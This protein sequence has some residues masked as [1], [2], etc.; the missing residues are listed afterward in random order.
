MGTAAGQ[1]GV[2]LRT[3]AL[4][5]TLVPDPGFARRHLALIDRAE[6]KSRSARVFLP[7]AVP[8][9]VCEAEGV[10]PD[11]ATLLGAVGLL[12]WAGADLLDDLAD[13]PETVQGDPARAT[14]VAVN[15]LTTLP[16]LVLARAPVSA[17]QRA[18]AA[19]RLATGLVDMSTG[20]DRDLCQG[21][22]RAET[23]ADWETVALGKS[24]AEAALHAGLAARFGGAAPA[25]VQAWEAW[26]RQLGVL[27]QA[28]DDL[29]EVIHGGADLAV[30]R[31]SLPVVL[32]R[33][34]LG[35]D[36]GVLAQVLRQARQ[37]DPGPAQDLLLRSGVL[38]AASAF[39]ALMARRLAQ[40]LP[41]GADAARFS[42]LSAPYSPQP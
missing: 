2:F 19:A 34:L 13:E 32:A 21:A 33:R 25:R 40:A 23:L 17:E 1:G 6:A 8:L 27:V 14:L 35:D 30:G 16:Q 9:R 26:G 28:H 12:V 41:G 11:T 22:H 20:Q 37:G 18:A 36:C 24:G 15:A 3:R 42:M 4:V 5:E 38:S 7:V 10:A 31:A 39:T 29:R